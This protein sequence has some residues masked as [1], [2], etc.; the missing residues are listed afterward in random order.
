M[1]AFLWRRQGVALGHG[2]DWSGVPI[3]SAVPNSMIQIGKR[4]V[5][6][7][8]STRTALGVNHP[9]VLRTLRPGAVLQIGEE[10]RMSGATICA[11]TRVII[12]SRCMIGANVTIV[13]TDFHSMDAAIRSS[14]QDG[15]LAK[16]RSVEIGDDV[17]I[18]GGSYILKG[19]TIGH[20]AVIGA[21]S[22]VTR[23]VAPGAMVAGNPAREIKSLS[24]NTNHF[25]PAD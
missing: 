24:V 21:A 20:R 8:R 18:G 19:V 22:V 17:F 1:L 10:V 25:S 16:T 9:V 14:P 11:A 13:D 3:V 4:C 7:S 2:I 12:G 15:Q 6:S 5:I 23:N